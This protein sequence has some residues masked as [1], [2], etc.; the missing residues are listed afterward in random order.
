MLC[1]HLQYRINMCVFFPSALNLGTVQKD[2][3]MII[4]GHQ[5]KITM[6]NSVPMTSLNWQ[7][8]N[9]PHVD[10]V[11]LWPKID[12]SFWANTLCVCC[13]TEGASERERKRN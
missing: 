11:R 7:S 5:F 9:I 1:R 12:Q 6:V 4:F 3:I 10:R 8:V 13:E 2:K